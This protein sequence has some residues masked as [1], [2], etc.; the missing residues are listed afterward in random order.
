MRN[1][2]IQFSAVFTL[3]V[4]SIFMSLGATSIFPQLKSQ[5]FGENRSDIDAIYVNQQFLKTLDGPMYVVIKESIES[6]LFGYSRT[7]SEENLIGSGIDVRSQEGRNLI[8]LAHTDRIRILY[9]F[10]NVVVGFIFGDFSFLL[11]NIFTYAG[12]LFLFIRVLGGITSQSFLV[13]IL[14]AGST[15]PTFIFSAMPEELIYLLMALY[16][17]YFYSI[18]VESPQYIRNRA[19][20]KNIVMLL[21][22]VALSLIKP[23][24]V[25]TLGVQLVAFL[26][27]NKN[28]R[29]TLMVHA[30]ISMISGLV[31]L[32]TKVNTGTALAIGSH[33][34]PIRAV[35]FPGITSHNNYGYSDELN[36][37][38]FPVKNFFLTFSAE[39]NAQITNLQNVS[40]IILLFTLYVVWK[41]GTLKILIFYLSI[42]I[43]VTMTQAKGGGLG[44]N[45]RWLNIFLIIGLLLSGKLW[46]AAIQA[47]DS[48][49]KIQIKEDIRLLINHWMGRPKAK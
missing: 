44:A 25:I 34:N 31:W 26:Y 41:H 42:I 16:L 3:V 11:L 8:Y 10:L 9:P 43:G 45:F 30:C 15:V 21:L 22:L 2:A 6:N 35:L 48:S 49:K 14:L 20:Q 29:R 23:I 38:A 46:N 7:E 33:E 18:F 4:I 1:R 40:L 27:C 24:F 37:A 5:F 39:I 19:R 32:V 28:L 12:L 17:Y 47:K 13:L 36:F